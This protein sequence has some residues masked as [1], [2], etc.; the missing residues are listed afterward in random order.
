MAADNQKTVNLI[1]IS[2]YEITLPCGVQ[3]DSRNFVLE[4]IKQGHGPIYTML[5][6]QDEHQEAPGY[7]LFLVKFNERLFKC[8]YFFIWQG[9]NDIS[10]F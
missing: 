1:G 9:Y 10:M 8:L 3:P 5:S 6:L 4:W 2:G 7:K